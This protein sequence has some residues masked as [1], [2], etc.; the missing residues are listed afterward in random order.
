V[1]V[2]FCFCSAC[3]WIHRSGGYTAEKIALAFTAIR[4]PFALWLILAI[5]RGIPEILHPTKPALCPDIPPE[6]A[7]AWQK[8][9]VDLALCP[10]ELRKQILTLREQRKKDALHGAAR[11]VIFGGLFLL[12]AANPGNYDDV[13]IHRSV[14]P[15]VVLLVLAMIFPFFYI[16][17]ARKR[18]MATMRIEVQLLKKAPAAAKITP[19]PAKQHRGQTLLRI[20]LLAAALTLLLYGFFTGGTADVLTKAAN[21]CTECI[22]LG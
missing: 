15:T 22:G 8:N 12:Y 5:G 16:W 21:I 3:L 20:A 4:I 14:I 11:L 7:L 19:P 10:P 2:G 13:Q 6:M 1:A 9:R 17:D 18:A